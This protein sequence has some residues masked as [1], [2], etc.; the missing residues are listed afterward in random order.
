LHP[1]G[2]FLTW[3]FSFIPGYEV[4]YL[5]HKVAY[6]NGVQSLHN[7]WRQ[8]YANA[9]KIYS[10]TNSRARFLIKNDI[11]NALAYYNA[12]VVA[13]N[14]E[15]VGLAPGFVIEKPP[16][17]EPFFFFSSSTSFGCLNMLD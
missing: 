1:G 17:G 11:K 2:T 12:G 15:V 5:V 6:V 13:V 10:A 14:S 8:S 3:V 9:V 7:Y 4:L 16:S